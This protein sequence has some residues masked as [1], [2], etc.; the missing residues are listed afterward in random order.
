[1]IKVALCDDDALFLDSLEKKLNR[2]DCFIYKYT[3]AD[4]LKNASVDF[5][6]AFIDIE[7]GGDST[8]FEAVRFLK[9]L[10]PKCVVAFFTNYS[11]YAIEGYEYRAFRYILKNEPQGLID[12][13][14]KEVFTEFYRQNKVIKGSYKDKTFAVALDDIY[15]MEIADHI[16]KIH[17][18]KGDFEVYKK[19]KDMYDELCEFGFLRCH[20]SYI[21]NIKYIRSIRSD[22]SFLLN[23]PTSVSIPIGI[24]YRDEA[25][26]KYLNYD[27]GGAYL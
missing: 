27:I 7:L 1:M 15:Y 21:V 24:R 2:Y 25:K 8:G 14:I 12:K 20:R 3:D 18:R 4:S 10:N 5:D 11:G 22:G 6:I 17:S 19:I 23:T 9:M 16:L 26:A 13:R